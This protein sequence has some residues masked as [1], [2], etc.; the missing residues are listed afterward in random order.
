MTAIRSAYLCKAKGPR[1][2]PEVARSRTMRFARAPAVRRSYG[3][4]QSRKGD[5]PSG[6]PPF[7]SRV[8]RVDDDVGRPELRSGGL[9]EPFT[10]MSFLVAHRALGAPH[11]REGVALFAVERDVEPLD[12]VDFSGSKP[13]GGVDDLEDDEGEDHRID[14]ARCTGQWL[15]RPVGPRCRRARHRCRRR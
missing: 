12:F 9:Y 5:R 4:H 1:R 15:A 13:D 11:L 2:Q 8:N 7:L 14:P 10:A 3:T 6:Q